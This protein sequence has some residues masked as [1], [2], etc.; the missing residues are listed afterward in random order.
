MKISLPTAELL[1]QLQTVTRVA[2]TRSAVQA[3]SGV[4]ISAPESA[5]PELR[6]TDMDIGLRAPLRCEVQ[7]P[8]SAV[9]PARLLLDVARSLA[10]D[11]TSLEVRSAEQDVE[12]ICGSATFAL[13]RLPAGGRPSAPAPTAGARHRRPS[14]G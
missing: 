4:M 9:L 10:A 3:L 2:S 8:G 12:L 7:R 11:E 6:A 5:D 1:A 13:R 14:A